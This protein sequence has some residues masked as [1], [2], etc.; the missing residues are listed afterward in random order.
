M[1]D[2]LVATK[3]QIPRVHAGRVTRPRLLDRLNAGLA[4][5]LALVSAPAGFGK[6]TLLAEWVSSL[7]WP[8]AWLTLDERDSDPVRFLAYFVRALQRI[9]DDAGADTLVSIRSAVTPAQIT[10]CLPSLVN[11]IHN[12]PEAFVLVLDDYHLVT[13]Q[14]VHASLA[15]LVEHQPEPMHLVIASRSD[16]PLPLARLR[17]RGQLNEIRQ[18]DLRFTSQEAEEMLHQALGSGEVLSHAGMLTERTEGWVAALQMASLALQALPSEAGSPPARVEAFIQTFGGT[19][20]H[21]ADFLVEEV[22]TRQSEEVRSF[23]LQTSILD[24]LTGPL[25]DAL[26]ADP[27]K[28]AGEVRAASGQQMLEYLERA[29]LFIE[30]LD[31]RRQWYRYHRLFADL[32][33]LRLRQA[34][35]AAPSGDRPIDVASL[36]RQ[37]SAWYKA[38]AMLPEAIQHALQAA[39]FVEA[40]GLIEQEAPSAWRQGELSTLQRWL[41][42]LPADRRRNHPMLSIYLATIRFLRGDSF[43]RVQALVEEAS[44]HDLAGQYTGEIS[45]LQAVLAL[46][47]GEIPAGL[48]LAEQAVEQMPQESH[49]Y[50][51]AT[52]V[53]SALHLLAGDLASA[54][55]L[56]E[57]DLAISE[58]AG[59]RLG[60][61][62]SVR[63]LGSLAFLRG[64]LRR[65]KIYY[66]R[67]LEL[68]RD[69]AGRLW[70][71]AGR[72]VIHLA[73]LA[74][75]RDELEAAEVH[76]SQASDLLENFVPGWNS[77]SYVLLARLE[78]ARGREQDAWA[79]MQAAL[80][81]A[82]TTETSMD[83]VYLE[84][85]AARLAIWQGDLVAAERWA[86]QW[87]SASGTRT[88]PA[89]GD[90]ERMIQSR[91]F[92]E[93]GRTTLARYHLARGEP[94]QAIAILDPP[95]ADPQ[96]QPMWGNRVEL[97][98]LRALAHQAMGDSARAQLD[99]EQALELAKPEGFVRTFVEEGDPMK[100][101]LAVAARQGRAKEYASYLLGCLEA[102]AQPPPA[103][104]EPSPGRASRSASLVEPLTERESEVLRFLQTSLTIP[105]IASEMGIAPSTVRT[106]V[107]N[108][109]GKLGVHRRLDALER[110]RELGLL[111]T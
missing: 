22:L 54:E 66:Q 71:V 107:K 81:R 87:T 84:I 103:E 34:A 105:E 26:L 83:D 37:A 98:A 96:D 86:S 16:P 15:F 20:R 52:R 17:A 62:A 88:E 45:M 1:P 58:R 41:E 8:S 109:Y 72:I 92:R 57:Q 50:G 69:S 70:P 108:V 100:R 56:L 14:T 82:R 67:A 44:E 74:L 95:L 101:L 3:L 49:F 28:S 29:N 77:E 76:L 111:Q 4:C 42:S 13:D 2:V 40:A 24:R 31:D 102:G 55:R 6:T 9:E 60:L 18:A 5:P 68:S 75:E 53:L 79:A 89:A 85:Q 97:L 35:Q 78:H 36:H 64:E 91:L 61:S 32:L 94:A 27:A 12:I 48:A 47:R 73:E 59:D 39:D 93:I 21:V 33:R 46:Y 51:L 43:V 7:D 25:C 19:H 80:E 63:R 38:N 99:L 30:P 23:L 10:S 104:L 106:F 90:I 11:D 110:A 65:A